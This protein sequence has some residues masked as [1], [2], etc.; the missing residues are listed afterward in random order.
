MYWCSVLW[1][2]NMYFYWLSQRAAPSVIIFCC[3][4]SAF[5]QAVKWRPHRSPHEL[6]ARTEL[7]LHYIIYMHINSLLTSDLWKRILQMPLDYLVTIKYQQMSHATKR[8][9]IYKSRNYQH[10]ALVGLSKIVIF[11]YRFKRLQCLNCTKEHIYSYSEQSHLW[12][13]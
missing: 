4:H 1:K 10:L 6:V 9:N 3:Q 8:S 5:I 12:S 2:F 11:M 13:I 7:T